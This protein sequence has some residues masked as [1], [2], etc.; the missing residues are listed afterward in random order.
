MIV[1]AIGDLRDERTGLSLV[2]AVGPWRRNYSQ[3]RV[4][5]NRDH[6]LLPQIRGSTSLVREAPVYTRIYLQEQG[7][8]VISPCSG[9]PFRHLL[10][11]AGLQSSYCNPPPHGGPES[12]SPLY[13]FG[14]NSKDVS[15]IIS[16]TILIGK[17]TWPQ[18]CYLA[19]AVV[20]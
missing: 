1:Q 19:K 16:R 20:F 18:S 8:P 2:T 12:W 10:R 17:T 4:P 7:G 15:S 14:T 11:L 5:R 3:A 6:I 13:S 9:L